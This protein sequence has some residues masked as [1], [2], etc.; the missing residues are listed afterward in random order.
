MFAIQLFILVSRVLLV[1]LAGAGLAFGQAPDQTLSLKARVERGLQRSDLDSFQN[2]EK[3][4]PA[5]GYDLQMVILAAGKTGD[6]F[7][8]P[9]LKPFLRY[10][11]NKNSNLSQLA[12]AAQLALAKLGEKEQLQEIA[13]EAEYGYASLQNSVVEHKLKYVG[14]W[15]SLN[16]LGRW[17]D[18]RHSIVPLLNE[19]RGD[20]I[21]PSHR[22]YSLT[23][24]PR[25][26]PNPPA[27]APVPLYLQ[28]RAQEKLE[29]YRRRGGSGSKRTGTR[30]GIYSQREK[31]LIIRWRPARGRWRMTSISSTSNSRR[32]MRAGIRMGWL[33]RRR[34]KLKNGRNLA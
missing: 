25:I 26:A 22:E 9:Y 31:V 10:S 24:L 1:V 27:E 30:Y 29:P 23:E 17:L 34:S 2:A 16:L 18:E 5:S 20:V 7:W 15:F 13:C 3:T 33:G 32:L 6:A 12:G 21:Y 11:R 28:T 8:V 4:L 19:P 14:G